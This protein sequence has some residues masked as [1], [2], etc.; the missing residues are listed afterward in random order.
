MNSIEKAVKRLMV[1][2]G[3]AE[4]KSVG[5]VSP[6][7]DYKS[8][9]AAENVGC[10]IDVAR[11][12]EYGFLTPDTVDQKLA[13]QYRVLKRPLLL[14][15]FNTGPDKVDYSNSLMITS[16]IEGEGKTYTAFNLAIS[17]SME[18]NTTVLLVDS[19]VIKCS[20]SK[21]LGMENNPGLVDLLSNPEMSLA[22]VIVTTDIPRLKVLPAGR[23]DV[24]STELLASA[25]MK[26][27]ADELSARYPDRII[28]FD[29]PPLLATSQAKV[30]THIAGQILLVVEAGATPQEL[31]KESVSQL[32]S[33]KIIGVVLNKSR[34]SSA[35]YYGGYYGDSY[36]S[37]G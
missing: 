21:L 31:V 34:T 30:I 10:R 16:A 19:D 7:T 18:R 2:S 12:K 3:N 9:A 1:G 6:V 24:H 5:E 35:G 37:T 28:L 33:N 15:A 23:P 17:M 32:D 11:L 29:A 8:Q 25:D 36:G 22:D 13:E 27:I 26:R 4:P 20:L 14:N